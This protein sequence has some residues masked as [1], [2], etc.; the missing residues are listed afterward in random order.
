MKK[1][2]L[3]LLLSIVMLCSLLPTTALAA[4][5]ID[6]GY[7][8]FGGG[9]SVPS[10]INMGTGSPAKY[11]INGENGAFG[12]VTEAE[13]GDGKWNAKLWENKGV[14]TLTL[15]NFNLNDANAVLDIYADLT[16]QLV[17]TNNITNTGKGNIVSL[18]ENERAYYNLT[19]VGEG[20]LNITGG[21]YRGIA[22]GGNLNIDGCGN[23]TIT[24]TDGYTQY[25]IAVGAVNIG[26][27]GTL[28]LSNCTQA[29]IS[30]GMRSSK[31]T[32]RTIS[33]T[34]CTRGIG[35]GS[36]AMTISG[37]MITIDATETALSGEG[38]TVVETASFKKVVSNGG[39]R[40]VIGPA[41]AVSASGGTA[42]KATAAE[43]ETVTITADA[44]PS[45]KQ[46]KEWTGV[47]G[48]TFVEDTSKTSATAKFT[49]P[50][51]T[52][53]VT[54][55]YEDI[56]ALAGTVTIT[57]D[58]KFGAVLTADI[59]GITNNSGTLSYQWKRGGDAIDGATASTYTLT[60]EDIGKTITVVVTSSVETG[61]ITS[62][63]TAAV[64][65]A[66]SSVTTPPTAIPGLAY[67]GSAQEL[68]SG[69]TATGGTMQYKVGTGNWS[70]NIPTETNAGI[71]TVYYKV[72]GDS[73]HSDTDAQSI[74]VTLAQV[75]SSVTT[76][77]TA[78]ENLVYNGSAQDLITGGTA[79][80]GPMQY[81]LN[82]SAWKNDIPTGTNAG[83]YTVACRVLGDSNHYDKVVSETF[84]VTIA[85]KD[86]TITNATVSNKSYDGNNV[87]EVTAVT[88]DG[89]VAQLVKDT[90]YTVTGTF[91]DANADASNVDV[92]ISVTLKGN[93]LTNYNLANANYT[94]TAKINKANHETYG[95]TQTANT[96]AI[97]SVPGDKTYTLP[98]S[99]LE[100]VT[101]TVTA[102]TAANIVADAAPTI[103]GNTLTYATKNCDT[104]NATDTITVTISSTNYN[105]ITF[106]LTVKATSKQIVTISGVSA[107]SDLVYDGTAK[108]DYTGTIS[109]DQGWDVNELT[110]TY[111]L[112]DG[113]TK[114]TE[115]NSGAAG[116]G[117]APKNAGS[118]K[119]TF[120]VPESSETHTG[121]LTLAFAIAK[122]DGSVTAPT[123][124]TLAYTGEA[125]VLINAGSSTTGEI[126]YKVGDGSYSTALPT[127]TTAGTYTVYY[128]VVG[129]AN[130]N[131][132]A[133]ASIS[134]TIAKATPTGTPAYT[135][136]TTTGKTLADA[137]LN[138]GV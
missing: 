63:A 12:T 129:D 64:A 117:L 24:G 56:P 42:D 128:K 73:S 17:G 58:A 135:A 25:N 92:A 35:V 122:A 76:A 8:R 26:G 79:E 74:S 119:V 102:K 108:S 112:D 98:C 97:M 52:V 4:W 50:A 1:R 45:G 89:I 28:T 23:I 32:G 124:K 113:T 48:L 6:D 67:T 21:G 138:A 66:A 82:G 107:A 43:G 85:K 36:N 78:K 94:A 136:I 27:T 104:E 38:I 40:V 61:E 123:A 121:N 105:D 2:V 68:I 80:G 3:S 77:P 109:C 20:D 137:A 31:I 51:K 62:E 16:I 87:A 29:G 39:K 81:S 69:G 132:V 134:V 106:T 101:Y 88:F 11:Y 90:D 34:N 72:V 110:I 14:L 83:T 49:M 33:I 103:T 65:K 118:Y 70:T 19:I 59:T 95:T 114:T 7:V 130:H 9:Y 96:D 126:Q 30:A 15:N 41:Y 53:T 44:A 22:G 84:T 131:D 60:A 57:G 47:D 133:E 100:G 54:A 71:Y 13:P 46:F 55:T 5:S 86:I 116:E 120:A 37:G 127:A 115:A 18:H 93:A 111:Y 10:S 75:A 99:D 91:P 125:Q